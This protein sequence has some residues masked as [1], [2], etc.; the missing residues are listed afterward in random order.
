MITFC[1]ANAP[2]AR[3]TGLQQHLSTVSLCGIPLQWGMCWAHTSPR[4]TRAS[5]G[6]MVGFWK[7]SPQ[8]MDRRGHAI[9]IQA[10]TPSISASFHGATS[11]SS[12]CTGDMLVLIG[13]RLAHDPLQSAR[14]NKNCQQHSAVI[15]LLPSLAKEKDRHLCGSYRTLQIPVPQRISIIYTGCQE[16]SS[17][18]DGRQVQ[19][20]LGTQ[21]S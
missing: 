20:A 9:W 6:V 15:L 16:C 4:A 2:S 10:S 5:Y 8:S 12:T 11:D 3:S 14:R 13:E 7:P 17:H 21:F 1:R 18:M 19:S